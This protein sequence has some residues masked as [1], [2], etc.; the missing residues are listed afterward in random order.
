MKVL[1]YMGPNPANVSGVSWKMWKIGRKGRQVTAWWGKATISRHRL[2]PVN[3]LATKTWR[4]R[5]E[6][7]AKEYETGRVQRKLGSGYE[8]VPSRAHRLRLP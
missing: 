8:R 4:F 5:T 2:V 1:V 7:L 6:A 3:K